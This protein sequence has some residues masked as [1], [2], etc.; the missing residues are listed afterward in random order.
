LHRA[1]SDCLAGGG[2]FAPGNIGATRHEHGAHPSAGANALEH[3]AAVCS[4]G[5]AARGCA[6]L[7]R[8]WPAPL[9]H[10]VS[11]TKS[12]KR[13]G[14]GAPG[15]GPSLRTA[16]PSRSPVGGVAACRAV[17][18]CCRA[19]LPRH[20]KGRKPYEQ[21]HHKGPCTPHCCGNLRAIPPP[22]RRPHGR[23]SAMET[24]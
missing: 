13:A 16:P 2:S 9:T 10:E 15:P 3:S 6:A 22:P 11:A 8:L 12:L 21:E 19:G 17:V 18:A 24:W 20:G 4:I 7:H 1:F 14:H 23:P 5:I